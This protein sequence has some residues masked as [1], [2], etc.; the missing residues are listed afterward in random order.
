M[1]QWCDLAGDGFV[2]P[3]DLFSCEDAETVNTMVKGFESY[4]I[5]GKTIL[6]GTCAKGHTSLARLLVAKYS[7]D[8]N[9]RDKNGDTPFPC[10]GLGGDTID[11]RIKGL[12]TVYTLT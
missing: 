9:G 4:K 11:N 1:L 3:G 7:C 8:L 10:A 12:E 5:N 6:H 2:K